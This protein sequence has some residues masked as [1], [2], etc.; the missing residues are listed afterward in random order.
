MWRN[1]YWTIT[2]LN[3]QLITVIYVEISH[4]RIMCPSTL[5][6]S[7]SS[8]HPFCVLCV[9]SGILLFP[10]FKVTFVDLSVPSGI[11]L[12]L[13]P[14]LLLLCV[15]DKGYRTVL[16]IMWK[17]KVYE[18]HMRSVN[19]LWNLHYMWISYIAD[20]VFYVP[21]SPSVHKRE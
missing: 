21:S 7:P 10:S 1:I 18:W 8:N 6:F 11:L 20:Y 5:S 4:N 19:W 9:P 17:E 2:P 13:W 15:K 3:A 12:L 14:L 16:T